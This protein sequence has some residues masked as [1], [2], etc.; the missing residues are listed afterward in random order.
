M[1]ELFLGSSLLPA[2]V[3]IVLLVFLLPYTLAHMSSHQEGV[4]H[5]RM[6]N[7]VVLW[8]LALLLFH[9]VVLQAFFVLFNLKFFYRVDNI[10]RAGLIVVPCLLVLIA[11][12]SKIV[13]ARDHHH[14]YLYKVFAG[15]NVI[16]CGLITLVATI[17]LINLATNSQSADSAV[18]LASSILGVY[19]I[20]W[21]ASLVK[22]VNTQ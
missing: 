9:V 16:F 14:D 12:G 6:G 21:L 20:I 13:S 8:V 15:I 18:T 5:A 22:L 17:I 3:P 11:V 10:F 4:K 7:K 1:N 19:G 2:M